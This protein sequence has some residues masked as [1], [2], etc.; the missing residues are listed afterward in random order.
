LTLVWGANA[1]AQTQKSKAKMV[2]A[3]TEGVQQPLY[4][5][6]RGVHLGMTTEETRAK[7]GEPALKG[8]DQDFYAFSAN[9]TA[10]IA[11]D[12]AH[13]VVT[14]S[15]DYTGGIGAPDHRTVVGA[16]LQVEPDGSMYKL[17][18]Y[19][20]EGYWVSYNKSAGA[21]PVVTITLQLQK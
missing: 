12:A 3:Y 2:N 1:S 13:K 18:R 10:Q 4:R 14:I 8:D 9:E 21:L 17:V 5:E 6:Y 20:R 11:Y 19:E 15:I 16:D 7:L